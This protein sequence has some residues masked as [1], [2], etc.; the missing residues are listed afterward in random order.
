MWAALSASALGKHHIHVTE[1]HNMDGDDSGRGAREYHVPALLTE[2]IE[3]LNIKPGGTYVDATF[4]GGG[5]SREIMR[6][7]GN[8]GRLFAFDQDADA[9]ANAVETAGFTFVLSNFR[10]VSNWMRYYGVR[11]IDGLLADLGVSSHHLDEPVRGFSFRAA[12]A[13][14][15]MRM[16]RQS[17]ITAADIVNTADETRLA[18]IFYMYGELRSSHRLAAAI[19]RERTA[20]S[21]TTTGQLA[22]IVSPLMPRGRESKDMARLFQALRIEVNHEMDALNDLLT[23]ATSLLAPGGRLVVIAYH[24][25]EDRLVKNFI[26]SGTADGKLQSD[27]YGNTTAPLRAVNSRVTVPSDAE[28]AANPRS[29]SARMRIAE[30]V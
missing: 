9:A 19:V 21:I 7:L 25:L 2:S 29:R 28:Q 12:D 17:G 26:R 30:K 13:P 27:I 11:Q 5:H 6:R 8:G 16:N 1:K 14:L 20:K 4:G 18:D 24:S 23:S 10:Y 3:G 15:D 22:A